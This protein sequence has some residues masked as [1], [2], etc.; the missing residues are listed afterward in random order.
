MI[1]TF[2][3]AISEDDLLHIALMSCLTPEVIEQAMEK[4]EYDVKL[5]VNGVELDPTILNLFNEKADEWVETRAKKMA[6]EKF[7]EAAHAASEFARMVNDVKSA[8]IE[9]YGVDINEYE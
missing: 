7:H 4:K 3:E 6:A 5:V 1:I 2:Q 8:L 9:K